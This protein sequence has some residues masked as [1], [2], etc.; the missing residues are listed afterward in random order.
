[1]ELV[2]EAG[3]CTRISMFLITSFDQKTHC[4]KEGEL[5]GYVSCLVVCIGGSACIVRSH[6]GARS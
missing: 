2:N 6:S 3:D 4:E 5:Q 1:M